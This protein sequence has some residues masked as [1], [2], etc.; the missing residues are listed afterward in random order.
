MKQTLLISRETCGN[1]TE[2]SAPGSQAEY[3]EKK[4]QYPLWATHKWKLK[5]KD[6]VLIKF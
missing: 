4:Q 3:I 2:N 5:K 6:R 1:G